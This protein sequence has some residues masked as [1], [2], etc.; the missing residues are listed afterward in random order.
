MVLM[1]FPALIRP[2]FRLNHFGLFYSEMN[3]S[4]NLVN[5]V[6]KSILDQNKVFVS[7]NIIKKL[8]TLKLTYNKLI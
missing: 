4:N 6:D 7:F 1:H 3:F 5:T 8:R 2:F